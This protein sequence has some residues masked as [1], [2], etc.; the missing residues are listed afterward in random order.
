MDP[1]ISYVVMMSY[2]YLGIEEDAIVGVTT[3]FEEAERFKK[4]EMESEDTMGYDYRRFHILEF[5]GK[6]RK[7]IGS[8]EEV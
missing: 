4:E 5:R 6:E 7:I 1:V 2:S 8:I 3:D